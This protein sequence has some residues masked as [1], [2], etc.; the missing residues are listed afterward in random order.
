MCIKAERYTRAAAFFGLEMEAGAGLRVTADVKLSILLV[1]VSLQTAVV[2]VRRV[3]IGQVCRIFRLPNQTREFDWLGTLSIKRAPLPYGQAVVKYINIHTD[4][5]KA[6]NENRR[7]APYA[8]FL[9][10]TGEK[11]NIIKGTL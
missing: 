11:H 2:H 3:A 10:Y 8:K 7:P 9:R 5:W 1:S 4:V 6:S